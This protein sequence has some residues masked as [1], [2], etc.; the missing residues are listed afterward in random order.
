VYLTVILDRYDRKVIGWALSADMETV[1]T[2]I[3][4]IGT[5][6]ANR[7]AREGLSFH[8]DRGGAVLREKFS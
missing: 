4:A 6:F 7:K 1:H 2:T 5:A 3:P 8:S